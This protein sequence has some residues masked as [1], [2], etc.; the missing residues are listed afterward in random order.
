MVFNP[1]GEHIQ[2]APR[3]DARRVARGTCGPQALLTAA[4]RNGGPVTGVV[5][6]AALELFLHFVPGLV[7]V[8]LDRVFHV[9]LDVVLN[10]AENTYTTK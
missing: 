7:V 10:L 1:V 3:V 9:A 4:V 6:A 2:T 5:D 8:A